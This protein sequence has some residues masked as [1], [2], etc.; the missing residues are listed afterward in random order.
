MIVPLSLPSRGPGAGAAPRA[1]LV[2]LTVPALFLTTAATLPALVVLPFVP[3]G[4]ARAVRLTSALTAFA[5]ALLAHSR[6][7][8]R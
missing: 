2:A 5:T 6:E 8:E 4:V 1:L 3:G 7:T